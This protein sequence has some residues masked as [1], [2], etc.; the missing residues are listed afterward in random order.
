MR[1]GVIGPSDTK[2]VAQILGQRQERYLEVVREAARIVA[3]SG[4]RIVVTANKGSSTAEFARAYSK[5]DGRGVACVL[6]LKDREFGLGHA[7]RAVCDAE[8]DGKTWRSNAAKFAEECDAML[9]LGFGAGTFVEIG[10]AK[11]F[12]KSRRIIVLR[13][14]ISAELPKE[15]LSKLE[16]EYTR[17]RQLGSALEKLKKA[18]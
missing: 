9:C 7:E 11:W 14:C 17:V 8:I 4:F 6:P 3:A 5:A 1:I 12:L 18:L 13:E 2:K 16:V 10:M 15:A